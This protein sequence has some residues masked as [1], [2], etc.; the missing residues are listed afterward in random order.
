MLNRKSNIN[1]RVKLNKENDMKRTNII[2]LSEHFKEFRANRVKWSVLGKQYYSFK[3]YARCQEY[4]Y[5]IQV[6]KTV[7]TKN[8]ILF[9]PQ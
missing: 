8:I 9:K 2:D 5:R 6:Y 7:K 1:L 3:H 4:T